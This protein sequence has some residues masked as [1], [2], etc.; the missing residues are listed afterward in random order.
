MFLWFRFCA[1]RALP[2]LQITDAEINQSQVD[3]DFLLGVVSSWS[4]FWK[5][6]ST[7]TNRI[8]ARTEFYGGK[9]SCV[10]FDIIHVNYTNAPI[11][12]ILL[13]QS[14]SGL[15]DGDAYRDKDALLPGTF[16]EVRLM[17]GLNPCCLDIF[18]NLPVQR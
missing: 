11:G 14:P 16:Y 8:L 9:H 4:R 6:A 15:S 1:K 3:A 10:Y 5:L 7:W 13:E 2:E 17:T 18:Y 12:A